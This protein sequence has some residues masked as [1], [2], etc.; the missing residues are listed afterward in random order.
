MA[1]VLVPGHAS[2]TSS[3]TGGMSGAAWSA[4]GDAPWVRRIPSQTATTQ[5]RSGRRCPPHPEGEAQRREATGHGADLGPRRHSQ[6]RQR[7]RAPVEGGGARGRARQAHEHGRRGDEGRPHECRS[8]R[9]DPV[10]ADPVQA[11][12]A[13]AGEPMPGPGPSPFRRRGRLVPGGRSWHGPHATRRR[14]RVVPYTPGPVRLHLPSS[15]T[16]GSL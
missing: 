1:H 9:A 6:A 8:H 14:G 3:S 13:Q 12:P 10:Q 4:G 5:A 15:R 16:A 11:D 2:R 7:Q